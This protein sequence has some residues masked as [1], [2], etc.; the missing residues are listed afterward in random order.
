MTSGL[1]IE[2]DRKQVDRWADRFERQILGAF[3]RANR[4][5]LDEI[6]KN[7]VTSFIR[8]AHTVI[9]RPKAWTLR[10]IHYRRADYKNNDHMD[11]SSEIYVLPD[12]SAVLKYLMG[13]RTRKPGDVGP[14]RGY[15]VVPR[16]NALGHLGVKADKYGNLPGSALGRIRREAGVTAA[17]KH[18]NARPK[19]G[20]TIRQAPKNKK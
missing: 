9:D 10:G 5:A 15:I 11:A 6:A 8:D 7:A 14:S 20:T 18:A 13:V 16:W 2:I 12:Q 4:W 1:R 19:R 3:A 17:Q